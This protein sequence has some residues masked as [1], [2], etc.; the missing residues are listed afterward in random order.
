MP[1][2][3]AMALEV[4]V[5]ALGAGAIPETVGDD[6]GLVWAEPDP[7]LHAA[8]LARLRDD[9]PFRLG[10]LARAR[11]RYAREFAIPVLRDRFF[12]ALA[13]AL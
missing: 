1:L 10:L 13:E 8:S 2:V 9:A 11:R 3:E 12:A 6:G 7:W 5:V 4:P